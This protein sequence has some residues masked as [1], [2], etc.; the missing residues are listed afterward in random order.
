MRNRKFA[1]PVS[2]V[3]AVVTALSPPPAHGL[4]NPRFTPIH[5]VKAAT[6]VAVL[7]PEVKGAPDVAVTLSV[8]ETLKGEAAKEAHLSLQDAPPDQ[9]DQ[10]LK[11]LK[12]AKE[13]KGTCLL[14]SGKNEAGD[15]AGYVF[16]DGQWLSLRRAGGSKFALV[17][18]SSEML[19]TWNGGADML[20]RC[21]R[22]ILAHPD[23]AEVPSAEGM[24]WRSCVK[25]G[26]VSG[27]PTAMTV[28]ALGGAAGVTFV[29]IASA[30]GDVLL[31]AEKGKQQVTDVTG[32]LKLTAK[33][34]SCIWG[35]FS[36]TGRLDLLSYDGRGLLLLAQGDNGVF[37]SSEVK[38]AVPPGVVN[39]L[40][41]DTDTPGKPGVAFVTDSGL[42]VW[43]CDGQG[44]F[45]VA[46]TR[47]IPADMLKTLG[48]PSRAV[49][50]DFDGDG[51]ADIVQ[52]FEKDG[53]LYAGGKDFQL[54][55][56]RL[57]GAAAAKGTVTALGDF[58]AD[59]AIDLLM[60]G[61]G[62]TAVYQNT[63]QARFREVLELSGEVSY[64]LPTRGS[65]C[66]V[67]D[68]NNDGRADFV[69]ADEQGMPI[70]YFNRGFRSFGYCVGLFMTLKEHEMDAQA[71]QKAALLADLDSDGAQDAV[72]VK[73]NGE[74]WCLYNSDGENNPV[75]VRV[76]APASSCGPVWVEC[77]TATRGLGR[78]VAQAGVREARF[79]I[80]GG[81]QGEV[82]LKWQLPGQ[83]VKTKT[84]EVE[85]RPVVVD[86]TAEH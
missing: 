5:L 84:V 80:A 10:A 32:S 25:A 60:C 42:T 41:V 79:G 2:V 71:G 29:H 65:W 12:R 56:P 35:F 81:E 3:V 6:W 43:R 18:A 26:R 72:L 22:Y 77:Q 23:E 76:R 67:G 55:A 82:K 40:R 34:Q 46:Y 64:K 59:G 20:L 28:P 61:P 15:E 51:Y 68:F 11:A 49:V 53:I 69:L 7:D 86:L 66:D 47:E 31:K 27:T 75:N 45:V 48:Q 9:R 85:D 19:A 33:S 83:A 36:G 16:V 54:A 14:F 8:I 62:G 39:L 44:E 73:A 57:C 70:F 50:A 21:V 24:S 58:D 17:G 78:Q 30:D 4:I 13:G 1:E 38:A 52:P 74:L 63:G 37:R